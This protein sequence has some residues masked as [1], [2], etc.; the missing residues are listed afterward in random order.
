M[1]IGTDILFLALGF[2]VGVLVTGAGT[3]YMM[4]KGDRDVPKSV[5]N[6]APLMVVAFVA[7]LLF[8][9]AMPTLAQ[10]PPTLDIPI[11]TIF[12]QSNIW[13]NVF[14]PIA[15]IGIG[16]AIAIAVLNY[17]GKMIRSAF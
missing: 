1:G 5:R 16:I 9:S 11:D 10:D 6:I 4:R 12:D 14:A 17:V 15:A 8:T 13:I 2:I 7:L 3:A